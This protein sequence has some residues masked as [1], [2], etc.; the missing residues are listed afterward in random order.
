MQYTNAS[1]KV[2]Y[3]FDATDENELSVRPGDVVVAQGEPKDD[4][5]YVT[6]QA[7]GGR[8]HVPVGYVEP[9]PQQSRVTPQPQP[10]A[11]AAAAT[12]TTVLRGVDDL[13]GGFV[14]PTP[15]TVSP[16]AA[17]PVLFPA[18]SLPLHTP[19]F[20]ASSSGPQPVPSLMATTVPVAAQP[21]AVNWDAPAP[22]QWE[23]T[24]FPSQTVGPASEDA[25]QQQQP[26]V[27]TPALGFPLQ[28]EYFRQLD[29][30]RAA[31]LQAVEQCVAATNADLADC[32]KKND[33]LNFRVR[34]LEQA[35]QEERRRWGQ[36]LDEQR[37]ILS[38]SL[39]VY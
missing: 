34:E 26:V 16:A 12:V 33:D 37:R 11:P 17:E 38:T 13:F 15:A 14:N 27:P 6:R 1:L 24:A 36:R 18:P 3:R 28:A 20:A 19:P 4:W 21:F 39:P 23:N 32:R 5:L 30:Q 2:L 8:G 10:T 35:V 22:P 25:Q 31:A 29:V 9:L 7:D